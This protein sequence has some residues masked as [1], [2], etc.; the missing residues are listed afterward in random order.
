[1][2]CRQ[3]GAEAAVSVAAARELLAREFAAVDPGR[4]SWA[5]DLDGRAI[6]DVTLSRID[7]RHERTWIS[8]W[9][10]PSARGRGIASAAVAAI[11]DHA[12]AELGLH[13]IE[14]AH[15]VDNPASR[16][17]AERC[18]FRP[19]GIRRHELLWDG[20]RHDVEGHGLLADDPRPAA[21]R[22]PIR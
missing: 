14:L 9:L 16:R 11:C 18:G 20:I 5:I 15:R 13:R 21:P 3:L 7:L 17:V 1:M 4:R 22:L 10:A 2:L 6:G 8:Y 12:F 19:E